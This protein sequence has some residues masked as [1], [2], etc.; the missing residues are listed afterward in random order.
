MRPDRGAIDHVGAG[1]AL[2]R[3]G[4]HLQHSIENAGFDPPAAP[5]E[6]AVLLAILFRQLTPLRAIHNMPSKYGRLSPAGR[7]S[8]PRSDGSNGPI[9]ANSSSATPIPLAQRRLQ[10]TA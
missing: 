4:E 1:V 5:A 6:H 7:Q 8:R 9:N 10:E 3:L 2:H